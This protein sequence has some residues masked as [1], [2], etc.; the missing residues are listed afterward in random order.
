MLAWYWLL[1]K[2][3]SQIPTIKFAASFSHNDRAH[4]NNPKT[5]ISTI[6]FSN[7][8]PD[9]GEFNLLVTCRLKNCNYDCASKLSVSAWYLYLK[10][11]ELPSNHFIHLINI[12]KTYSQSKIFNSFI[13]G[14]LTLHPEI[15][16]GNI[17]PQWQRTIHK[18]TTLHSPLISKKFAS[19]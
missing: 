12:L 17:C 13:I 1:I 8:W 14:N 18:T 16:F 4:T 15:S 2:L 9:V 6:R 11:S 5:K 3:Y 19:F 10:K 7:T